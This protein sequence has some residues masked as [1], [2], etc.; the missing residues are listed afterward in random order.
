ME[1]TSKAPTDPN[2]SPGS[3]A[4][5]SSSPR[6]G[7]PS[8]RAWENPLKFSVILT[9]YND[10]AFVASCLERWLGQTEQPH[11][12]ILVDDGSDQVPDITTIPQAYYWRNWLPGPKLTVLPLRH[13]GIV[14]AMNAGADAATGDILYFGGVDDRV[15]KDFVKQHVQIHHWESAPLVF[16]EAS[17]G[18]HQFGRPRGFCPRACDL[19]ETGHLIPS[20]A[21]SIRREV[22]TRFEERFRWHCDLVLF[23]RVAHQYGANFA[24]HDPVE[25]HTRPG[26]YSRSGIRSEEHAAVLKELAN[27]FPPG[28]TNVLG[29]LGLPMLREVV[30]SRNFDMLTVPFL[31]RVLWRELGRLVLQLRGR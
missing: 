1:N 14:A 20:H 9:H 23:H 13:A 11:E 7:L 12:I 16:G 21:T 8:A 27:A 4:T 15:P 29:N 19:R 30:R 17:F 31:K 24:P 25:I 2:T 5:T 28:S 26:S 3:K 18:K 6:S 22:F 10:N